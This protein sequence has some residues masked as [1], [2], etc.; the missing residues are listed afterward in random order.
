[1][2]NY[3]T[4]GT[5]D[6]TT[7]DADW[8][9][10]NK[11]PHRLRTVLAN[12][13]HAARSCHLYWCGYGAGLLISGL[14]RQCKILPTYRPKG[15]YPNI[16]SVTARLPMCLTHWPAVTLDNRLL[17]FSAVAIHQACGPHY[18]RTGCGIAAFL[19]RWRT[20]L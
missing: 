2:L 7:V 4:K 6:T 11:D 3:K 16:H 5:V 10:R 18:N 13:K 20:G 12:S 19:S 17:H 14:M 15:Q 1:M 8:Y 9:P